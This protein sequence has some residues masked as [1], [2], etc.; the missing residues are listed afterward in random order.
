MSDAEKLLADLERT[1]RRHGWATS[2]HTLGYYKLRCVK[3]SGTIAVRVGPTGR[4][5][6]VA[7]DVDGTQYQVVAPARAAV[8]ELF[9]QPLPQPQEV[10]GDR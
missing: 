4:I 1:A 2:R 10:A 9:T 8:E 6:Q 7:V 3:D 5:G